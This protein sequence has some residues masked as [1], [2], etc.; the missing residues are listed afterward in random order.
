MQKEKTMVRI[1]TKEEALAIVD[2]SAELDALYGTEGTPERAKFDEE[3]WNF[4]TCQILHN[5]NNK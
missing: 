2:I 1:S 3:A 4:Y 5:T